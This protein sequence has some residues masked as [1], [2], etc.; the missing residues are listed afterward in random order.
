MFR[1][2]TFHREA[3]LKWESFHHDQTTHHL[4]LI[5]TPS[6]LLPSS[7]LPLSLSLFLTLTFFGLHLHPPTSHLSTS[8]FPTLAL[9]IY[10]LACFLDHFPPFLLSVPLA[11][12]SYRACPVLDALFQLL[13]P[14][15]RGWN[16][17]TFILPCFS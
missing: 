13:L 14:Q 2:Q 4:N 5:S 6:L 7:V 1:V 12:S 3:E 8:C 16:R 9:V 11:S 15:R 17:T 10:S